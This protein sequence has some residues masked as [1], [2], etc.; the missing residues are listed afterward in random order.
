MKEATISKHVKDNQICANIAQSDV[1]LA[2]V[3]F[4]ILV[5]YRPKW[6]KKKYID[7]K[8]QRF[9]LTS[10][11]CGILSENLFGFIVETDIFIVMIIIQ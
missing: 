4:H 6:R 3:V 10:F 1:T 11:L 2:I 9:G 7:L 8:T 5:S